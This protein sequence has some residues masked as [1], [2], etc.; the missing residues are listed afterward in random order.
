[1]FLAACL[2]SALAG[3]PAIDPDLPA[4]PDPPRVA[5]R[6]VHNPEKAR[7]IAEA[8]SRIFGS[9]G[10]RDWSFALATGWQ[11]WPNAHGSAALEG[12]YRLTLWRQLTD[13]IGAALLAD[14]TTHTA[15][16]TDLRF[17]NSHYFIGAAGGLVRWLSRFRI[18]A[19]VSLGA[20]IRTLSINARDDRNR[21]DLRVDPAFGFHGG[22]AVGIAGTMMLGLQ[23]GLRVSGGRLEPQITLQLDVPF[24]DRR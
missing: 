1:M 7:R 2:C 12:L 18:H 17:S 3:A 6:R 15:G 13:W 14:V 22:G 8:W 4:I 19:V 5:L 23:I 11:L 21:R 24:G 16:T 9:P 20:V 10:A